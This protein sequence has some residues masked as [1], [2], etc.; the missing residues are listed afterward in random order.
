MEQNKK[1]RIT[2]IFRKDE[3]KKYPIDELYVCE[4]GVSL[5]TGP[6]TIGYIPSNPNGDVQ[7]K[8][9][10]SV[11]IDDARKNYIITN[12]VSSE[13]TTPALFEFMMNMDTAYNNNDRCE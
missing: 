6:N 7:I 9:E 1:Y 12:S 4:L 8:V 11:Q 10:Q 2:N 3:N 13:G 5:G